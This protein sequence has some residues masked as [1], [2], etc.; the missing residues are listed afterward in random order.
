MREAAETRFRVRAPLRVTLPVFLVCVALDL[1]ALRPFLARTQLARGQLQRGY[2]EE[3]DAHTSL[4]LDDHLTNRF[5][6][7]GLSQDQAGDLSIPP[8]TTAVLP[9]GGARAYRISAEGGRLPPNVVF[10]VDD[11]PPPHSIE[12]PQTR[13]S[14]PSS[15]LADPLEVTVHDGRLELRPWDSTRPWRQESLRLERLGE[16][17]AG[18]DGGSIT[19]TVSVAGDQLSL[20]LGRCM[21]EVPLAAVHRGL[22]RPIVAV[23]AGLS[24]DLVHRIDRDWETERT[25]NWRLA[26]AAMVLATAQ[27]GLFWFAIDPVAAAATSLSL[28]AVGLWAVT[29]SVACALI[30]LAVGIGAAGWR[31]ISLLMRVRWRASHAAMLATVTAAAFWWILMPGRG[32]PSSARQDS[33]AS[34]CFLTGY[35][36]ANDSALRSGTRGTGTSLL[37]GC[38]PCA[39]SV[40][41]EARSGATFSFI[42][43]VA[44][45]SP[46][47][48]RPGGTLIFLGGTNDDLLSWFDARS[49]LMQMVV[50]F[51]SFVNDT[52]NRR[53]GL[54]NLN[55]LERETSLASLRVMD[56]QV[57]VLRQ[58]L[59]CAHNAGF[60]L[61]FAH[62]FLIADLEAGRPQER[63]AMV[64]QRRALLEAEG[65]HFIDLLDE[66]GSAA[67]VSWFNDFIHPSMIGHRQ[68]SELLCQR[69]PSMIDDGR[70]RTPV[71]K[72]EDHVGHRT[73]VRN[74]ELPR[75]KERDTA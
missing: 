52:Y 38:A 41:T 33:T 36:T 51:R 46:A 22:G 37:T 24:W 73:G 4:A 29:P 53:P 65:V 64:T 2:F 44:C 49:D 26:L 71:R 57:D 16:A 69:L 67:G 58:I 17:C 7:P 20:R 3:I 21:L 66:F 72:S 54:D 74:G 18:G 70:R 28:A 35:S 27:V 62:D 1:V 34:V 55:R 23:V 75:T 32:A 25:I 13:P 42:R 63:Q 8:G 31:A 15:W 11:H 40:T 19:L 47:P 59:G 61:L 12:P 39:G 9:L 56:H 10:G 14:P 5:I 43:D 48:V 30:A 68:I 45:A 6:F 60:S 50:Q